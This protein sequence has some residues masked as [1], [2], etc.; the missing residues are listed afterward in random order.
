MSNNI[1][2]ILNTMKDLEAKATAKPAE[3]KAKTKLEESIDTLTEKWNTD[4]KT[5]KSEQGKYADKT[6]AE[7]QSQL[8]ALKKSGPHKK[9]SAEYEKQNELEFALRAKHKWGKVKEGE[10][11][12]DVLKP[13][14]G[15]DGVNY[16]L[17]DKPESD[18]KDTKFD[19]SSLADVMGSRHPMKKPGTVTHRQE[20]EWDD[21]GPGD[22]DS[23]LK[24]IPR[25]VRENSPWKGVNPRVKEPT[26]A[27]TDK[28]A[29][30][31]YYP[32]PKPQ[33]KKLAKPTNKFDKVTKEGEEMDEMFYFGGD[34]NK[35]TYQ[36]DLSPAARRAASRNTSKDQLAA[37]GKGV[38]TRTDKNEYGDVV[39]G[40]TT[41]GNFGGVKKTTPGNKHT[42][43]GPQG[44]LPEESEAYKN[45][46]ARQRAAT[47][48]V[49]IQD[50]QA[51]MQQRAAEPKT[52]GQRVKK[53]IG[54]PLAQ[55]AKGNVNGAFGLGEQELDEKAINKYAIGMAAAKK[56]AGYGKKPAHNLP[57]SVIKKGHEIAKHVKESTINR[58]VD[59]M[60]ESVET[61]MN[62][63][64]EEPLTYEQ[65]QLKQHL[66]SH[67]Y[68]KLVKS[69]KLRDEFPD[70]LYDNLFSFYKDEMPYGVVNRRKGDPYEWINNR[71]QEVFPELDEAI[72]VPKGP[73][74]A[75]RDA[76]QL[77]EPQPEFTPSATQ[78]PRPGVLSRA[79]SAVG[80]G[81]KALG[82]ALIG[83]NDEE[84][85]QHTKNKWTMESVYKETPQTKELADMLRLS[86]LAE[87]KKSPKAKADFD[88]DGEV[89]SEK[90]EVQDSH[91]KAAGLPFKESK[92]DEKADKDYDGD[93]K[94][95]SGKDEYLGSKIAA[96]KKAGKLKEGEMCSTCKCDPCKCDDEEDEEQLD[97]CMAMV[98]A[99][100]QDSQ[101]SVNSSMDSNGN[102]TMTI[103]ASGEK[104][105]ELAQ[106]LR[107]AGQQGG[108]AAAEPVA[109]AEPMEVGAHEG[110]P[111]IE[112]IGDEQEEAVEEEKDPRYEANTT[113]EEHV[114]PPQ[115]LTKGGDG[116]VAGR[117]KKMN[118]TKPTWKNGDNAMSEGMSTTLMRE[119]ESIKVQK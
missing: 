87:S 54:E 24:H 4:Y 9:G 100:Q 82:K 114:M 112:V 90:D 17:K 79:A 48:D 77:A 26:I 32:E 58:L 25:K 102:K 35:K 91:R 81:A 8:S 86:G 51:R 11:D 73:S 12:E 45:L 20:H 88:G 66:G 68:G 42:I 33:V 7:L 93:G 21:E 31:G 52:F 39:R 104:A 62:S 118:P 3:P 16:A 110:Q 59:D 80:T 108:E 70:D 36:R 37:R 22:L 74:F 30:S 13:K 55:L 95:E 53:D 83:H 19:S 60:F 44:V 99:Q 64:S 92:A 111:E 61:I 28:K 63:K 84:L 46:L 1:Y 67:L 2:N 71:L 85:A 27:G 5:P 34:P 43:K 14:Y 98:G 115:T 116:D 57:K 97:E 18:P 38:I 106:L 101:F 96:A 41:T 119:Y 23:A 113:P 56:A 40:Q 94:V 105:D 49:R 47:T 109:I 78:G 76:M 50:A 72:N 103:S 6:Q 15:D 117:E 89:E 107:L 75:P 69:M 29:K 10:M 65:D